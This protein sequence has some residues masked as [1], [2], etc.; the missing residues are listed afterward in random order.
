VDAALL[1]TLRARV[2]AVHVLTGVELS[3]Y[4][5]EGRTPEAAV[6]PGTVEEVRAVVAAAAE[7]RVPI[8]PWGGGTASAVGSPG[9]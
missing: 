4:V 1:D 6:F 2:G 5:V 8:I 3:P 9:R 7:A